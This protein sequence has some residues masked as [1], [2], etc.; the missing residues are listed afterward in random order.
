MVLTFSSKDSTSYSKNGRE[1]LPSYSSGQIQGFLGEDTIR[2]PGLQPGSNIDVSQTT[3]AQISQLA[4]N[5]INE[6]KA[7]GF[8]GLG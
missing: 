7:S 3:F 8:L 6:D 1:W 2:L 4:D 5:F